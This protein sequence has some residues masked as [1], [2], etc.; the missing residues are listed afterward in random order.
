ME[1]QEHNI[2]RLQQMLQEAQMANTILRNQIVDLMKDREALINQM[3]R[4]Q[5]E[6][7]Y[8]GH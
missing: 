8:T 7:D 3:E 1:Q 4:L 2:F 5:R 6:K